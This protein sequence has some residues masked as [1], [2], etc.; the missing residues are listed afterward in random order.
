MKKIVIGIM[1]PGSTASEKACA[2]AHELGRLVASEGWV[3]L[4]GG[5][6]MGVMNSASQGAKEGGGLTIG[7]IPFNDPSY[8]S[9]YVDIPIYTDMG[10]ARNNI[11]VL[12]SDVVVAVEAGTSPGTASELALTICHNKPLVIISDLETGNP[13]SALVLDFHDAAIVK[14]PSH[15]IDVVKAKLAGK[16]EQ[17]TK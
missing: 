17:I 3:V 12:S 6:N 7:I 11:N 15:A 5:R 10:L 9:D 14:T 8:V 1:G 13:M 4:T 2:V 16:I